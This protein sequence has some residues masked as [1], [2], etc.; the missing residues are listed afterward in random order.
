MHVLC[1]MYVYIHIYYCGVGGID[2]VIRIL[3]VITLSTFQVEYT[4]LRYYAKINVSAA[5]QLDGSTR[6]FD[7]KSKDKSKLKMILSY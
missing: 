7:K 3:I 4:N 5:I 6:R 1:T 2:K